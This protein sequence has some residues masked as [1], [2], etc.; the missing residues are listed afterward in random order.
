[1]DFERISP[2][3]ILRNHRSGDRI[4]PLGISG[5]KKVKSYFIDSKI[6]CLLRNNIP[7]L[8][9]ERSVIWIAGERISDRVRVTERTKKVLKAEMV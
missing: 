8:V 4:D 1:M 2:P 6:P 3:L 7:L 9:D 5:T